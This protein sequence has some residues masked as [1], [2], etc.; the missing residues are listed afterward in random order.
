M[1]SQLTFMELPLAREPSQLAGA[2]AA[3]LGFPFEGPTIVSPSRSAPPNVTRPPKGSIYWRMG[4]DEAPDEIRKYSIFYS[5]HH[6]GGYYPEIDRGLVLH[7]ALRMVDYGNVRYNADD[8]MESIQACMARVTEI[9]SAGAMP[10]VLG[11]DHTTPYPVLKAILKQTPHKIGLVVFDAHVDFS[12][13][14]DEYWASNQWLQL[15]LETGKI[16]PENVVEIGIRSNRS[17]LQELGLAESLGVRV[18]TIDEVKERGIAAVVQEAIERATRGSQGLY[19]SLD[20][21]CMEPSAVPS[22]KAPEIW[23]MTV[24]ELFYALRA[25]ARQEVIGF[26]VCEYSADYDLNGMGAQ[27]CARTVVEMLG[28]LALRKRKKEGE[29]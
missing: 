17:A 2:D 28:G 1:K 4:A 15:M 3:I 16:D 11:G 21:D 24:D 7:D 14:P 27:F 23:G 26:D 12:Y 20:I 8:T 18:V 25:L 19:V 9:V 29:R 13:T 10:I 6:N 22:Q 5:R